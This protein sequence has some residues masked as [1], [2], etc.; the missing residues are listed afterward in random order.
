MNPL[1]HFTKAFG[2]FLAQRASY[3]SPA[4]YRRTETAVSPFLTFPYNPPH[5]N[6]STNK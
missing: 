1:A 3:L 4:V 2:L 5:K 6:I